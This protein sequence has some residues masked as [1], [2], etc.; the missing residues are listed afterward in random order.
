MEQS[1]YAPKLIEL[2]PRARIPPSISNM[3][4][5]PA[6]LPPSEPTQTPA[7]AQAEQPTKTEDIPKVLNKIDDVLKP[8]VISNST[9][10]HIPTPAI[11]SPVVDSM[12]Q[13]ITS[14]KQWTWDEINTHD[15]E[16]DCW[17]VIH[18]K[19]MICH[20]L[21]VVLYVCC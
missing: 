12:K 10:N 21:L 11:M 19:V 2:Q 6:I 5:T 4:P 8:Q 1:D 18:G 15:V 7:Q 14:T 20:T 9:T 13:D 17:L 16:T 3:C